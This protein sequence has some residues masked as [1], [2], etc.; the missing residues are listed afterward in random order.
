M[1]E[2]LAA[3]FFAALGVV[4]GR[5]PSLWCALPSEPYKHPWRVSLRPQL[6]KDVESAMA[7]RF[8]RLPLRDL[9]ARSA[10]AVLAS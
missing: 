6:A 8:R 4:A 2:G 10:R 1:T 9:M 3:G 7:A 5:L